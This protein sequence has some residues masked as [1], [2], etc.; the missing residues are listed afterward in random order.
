MKWLVQQDPYNKMDLGHK[1]QHYCYA[2]AWLASCLLLPSIFHHRRL[3]NSP[4]IDQHERD[5]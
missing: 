4:R 5:L 1:R 2:L 3:E